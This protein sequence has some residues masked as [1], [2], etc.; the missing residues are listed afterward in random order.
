[1]PKQPVFDGHNDVLLKLWKYADHE[2]AVSQFIAGCAGHIDVPRSQ[3]G[4]FAGGFFAIYVPSPDLGI[5][6]DVDMIKAAYEL[7]LPSPVEYQD[8]L[9][10]A[11]SQAAILLEMERQGAVKICH[12][13]SDIRNAHKAG[14]MAAIMH[15]EGAEA[16]AADLEALDVFYAA[17]LRS[18]GPVWSRP[19]IF[20]EGVPFRFPSDGD[21]GEGLTDVGG[22]LVRKCN[23]L[24][25]LVDLSHLNEKGFW[26]VAEISDAPLV[27]THSNA[28]S[29]S[30]QA[31]NLTDAQLK[32]IGDSKGMVGLNFATAFL[33]PDGKMLRET[34]LSDMLAHLDHMIAMCGEDH[35][36]LGSDFDGATVPVG[37]T[38]VAGLPRLV[39][40]MRDHGY[41]T[42]RIDK[43]C[44]ENWM[45]VLE[46]TWK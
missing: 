44:F 32:A 17:G 1:M 23:E 36:G 3:K 21:I 27:A 14:V 34:P 25:V 12:Q 41:S 15:M 24:G 7:P 16:I 37:I 26:D 31:R 9:P 30:L 28:C 11:L 29:I 46:R 40:A 18:L 19:T 38:D 8:A 22:A 35:V 4:G 42:T 13:V 20:G 43:L 10:I 33:R 45:S 2:D 39:Q 5:D 6:M